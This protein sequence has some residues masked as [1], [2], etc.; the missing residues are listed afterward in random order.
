[1]YGV[2]VLRF[3]HV[4]LDMAQKNG[5]FCNFSGNTL[6]GKCDRFFLATAKNIDSSKISHLVQV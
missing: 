1:M 3:M 5:Y 2:F 4:K 6:W